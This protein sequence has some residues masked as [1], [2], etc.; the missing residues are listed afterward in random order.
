MSQ[1]FRTGGQTLVRELNRSIILNQLRIGSP[2]SRADMAAITGL[3]KTTV[4]SLVDELIAHSF[5]RE[6]GRHPS[7]GG[8]P[9]MLLE[10]DPDAG[11]IVGAEF[12][13]GY[14]NVLV[15]DFR[16][17]IRWRRQVQYDTSEDQRRVM[18]KLVGLL[19][20]A[21]RQS[22]NFGTRLLGIGISL[23]GLV[24]VASGTQIFAPN[25]GWR[26]VPVREVLNAKFD[27]PIF[28]D[29]DANAAALAE[30]Y[31]G[32]AQ[33]L[34]N[35][36]YVTG[37]V[38]I[39]IGIV[40]GGHIFQGT[41][42]YAGEAGHTTL[43]LN[44]PLCMC[45]NHGCWERLA[46]QRALI[47]RVQKAI[48]KGQPS[49]ICAPAKRSDQITIQMIVEAAKGG[50]AVGLRALQ[51]TGVYL[52]VGIANLINIFNPSAIALG[53]MLSLAEEFLMPVV[54]Q[55]VLERAMKESR[56][57]AQ[58][59]VSTFKSDACVM[60]GVALV[61]HDILSRPRLDLS[62]PSQRSDAPTRQGFGRLS[63]RQV[64]PSSRHSR[65][66]GGGRI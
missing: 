59:L 50:D 52:G 61:L 11:C 1:Q 55:V 18:S 23:T 46:S 20:Q 65:M 58:I 66:K 7:A 38:G 12:G 8:R 17:A 6:I 27:V 48:Q 64:G 42:G 39:G 41:T 53:G 30:R 45:G 62:L 13:V 56:E 9:A 19:R 31:L 34:D 16:A 3:N 40:L 26:N 63:T 51:E 49:S 21:V 4:S 15:T 24:D 10:L 29:N 22:Q 37:N 44:G 47:E 33:H 32:A 43:D 54:R 60:G 5:V 35:F 25:L 14:L 36:V 2:L 28:V 57:A